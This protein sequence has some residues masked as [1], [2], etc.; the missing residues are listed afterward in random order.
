MLGGMRGA[1]GIEVMDR[2][3][4]S[5]E[6]RPAGGWYTAR[7]RC[8][9]T[10]QSKNDSRREAEFGSCGYDAEGVQRLDGTGQQ[11]VATLDS[12]A[13]GC[14]TSLF[15]R[16]EFVSSVLVSVLLRADGPVVSRFAG[17]FEQHRRK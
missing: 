8:A 2:R 5:K 10:L 17:F 12:F 9:A 15:L 11:V 14:S 4:P 13:Q 6:L 3:S 16:P 7:V 1:R